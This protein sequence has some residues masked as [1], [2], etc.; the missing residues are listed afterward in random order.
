MRSYRGGGSLPA[1]TGLLSTSH[2][3]LSPAASEVALIGRSFNRTRTAGSSTK[4]RKRAIPS[5]SHPAIPAPALSSGAGSPETGPINLP[6][7]YTSGCPRQFRRYC[8]LPLCSDGGDHD[9]PRTASARGVVTISAPPPTA[10]RSAVY[11]LSG[12]RGTDRL[13]VSGRRLN[14]RTHLRRVR[15]AGDRPCN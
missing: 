1:R 10:A 5:F 11:S 4:P 13:T 15:P 12:S 2:R 14:E 3:R 9:R 7:N 8:R 6:C